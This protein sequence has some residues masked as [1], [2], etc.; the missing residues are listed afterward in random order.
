MRLSFA[1]KLALATSLLALTTTSAGLGYF[2][3]ITRE[4]V[5]NELADRL[6]DIGRTGQFLF[7]AEHRRA[8]ERLNDLSEKESARNKDHLSIAPGE[9]ISVLPGLRVHEIEKTDDFVLVVQVLRQ[10]KN[11]SRKGLTK[12]GVLSQEPWPK[13]DPPRVRYTYLL[14]SIPEKPDHTILK[15]IADADYEVG[16]E[17]GNGKIDP[18]EQASEIGK[19]YNVADQPGMLAAFKGSVQT[20]P[21]YYTDQWGRWMSAYVPILRDDGTVIAVM[22]IDMSADSQYNL[23]E[24]LLNLCIAVIIGS[25]ILAIVLSVILARLISRPIVAL[26]AGAERVKNR[27]YSTQIAVQSKD[28]LGI[29]ASSFNDMV[30]EVRSYAVTLE[31]RVKERTAE[32]NESRGQMSDILRNIQ[33]GILTIDRNGRVNSEYSGRIPE[34]LGVSPEG[35]QFAE[36]FQEPLRGEVAEFVE[37]MISN[38]FMSARM[39]DATNPLQD[40]RIPGA[41]GVR[42]LSFTFRA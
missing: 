10:I 38:P 27:D 29:L 19:L 7:T 18:E 31:D 41:S 8:I 33:E 2:Y 3:R 16:D 1:F 22:G 28:E 40:A 13:N 5:W 42:V 6:A 14:V 25:V 32:L 35:R 17:N 24:R 15:F 37:Q 26:R 11:A 36:L 4:N 12:L 21:E 34:M 30:R 9:S 39:F 23:L 20:S